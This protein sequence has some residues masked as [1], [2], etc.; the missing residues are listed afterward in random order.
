MNNQLGSDEDRKRNEESDMHLNIVKEGKPAGVPS[1]GAEGGKEQQRE[2]RDQR[3]NEQP[4]MQEFQ[5]FSGEMRP[6]KELEDWATQYQGEIVRFF[7][8]ITFRHCV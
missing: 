4:A 8:E 2:P 1:R 3:N 7:K 5:A 6:P